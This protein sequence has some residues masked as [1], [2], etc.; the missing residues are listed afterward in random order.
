[1]PYIENWLNSSLSQSTGYTPVELLYGDSKPDIFCK[2]LEKRA[3]QLPPEDALSD[4]ILKAYAHMKLRAAR[5]N[6]RR[7]TGK[8]KWQPSLQ[9]LVQVKCQPVS[10]AGQ[11]L[12]STFRR[13]FE[14]PFIVHRRAN[15]S[16]FELVDSK[17]KSREL[18]SLKHLKPY[19]QE[20]P[21]S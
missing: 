11:G 9:E 12:T 19:L 2:I 8:T 16:I 7:K 21:E 6:E 5:R 10:D 14:G 20:N 1:V 3:D 13:P 15:P 18:F 4:K 17:G